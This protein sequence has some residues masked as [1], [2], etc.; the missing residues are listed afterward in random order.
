MKATAE[1]QNYWEQQT[2]PLHRSDS[3]E[4]YQ[5]YSD[6][7]QL[8]FNK[9]QPNSILELGCGNGA[10]YQHLGFDNKRYT[11]VDF[12]ESM[13]KEFE[14]NFPSVNLV[15]GDASSYCDE[16]KYDLIFSNG[17]IQYFDG[18]MLDTHFKNVLKMLENDGLLVF[19]SV[20]WSAMRSE[21]FRSG[22]I[23]QSQK[24]NNWFRAKSV[25]L[26]DMIQKSR[27]GHWYS[28]E[29]ISDYAHKYDMT[30]KFYSSMNYMYRFHAV[31]A[32]I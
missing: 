24:R 22:M 27:M 18:A 13:L 17:V 11:G 19:A 7:L 20:P 26:V 32:K 15:C 28:L 25:E 29:Q 30:A 8:L 23:R 3:E 14:T 6:E 4:H 9:S 5:V 16:S 21:Y 2:A 1:W 12:A 31:L 10:L